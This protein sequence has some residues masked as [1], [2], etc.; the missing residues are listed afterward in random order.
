MSHIPE[1]V[2]M[3]AVVKNCL[4][5]SDCIKQSDCLTQPDCLTQSDF[6]TQSDHCH[7]CRLQYIPVDMAICS[8]LHYISMQ[9]LSV[10]KLIVRRYSSMHVLYE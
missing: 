3:V 7:R 9:C 2:K 8:Q 5:Q 1:R 4:I 10:D 6:L